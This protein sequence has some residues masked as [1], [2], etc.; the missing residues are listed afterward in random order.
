MVA[1]RV[2]PST[3]ARVIT[4]NKGA[5][6]QEST[7]QTGMTKVSAHLSESPAPHPASMSSAALNGVPS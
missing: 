1:P 3:H 2:A 5:T 4:E 6:P 7:T